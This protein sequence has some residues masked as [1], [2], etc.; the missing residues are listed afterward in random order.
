MEATRRTRTGPR[1]E[2]EPMNG[3]M[4]R[5]DPPAGAARWNDPF[6]RLLRELWNNGSATET[7]LLS[8]AIDVSE[9]DSWIAV[10][11][12]L[13]GL[14]RKDIEVSV[15]DGVLSIRGEKRMEEEA[16]DAKFHR[17]ERRY[18]AFYRALSL[19]ETVDGGNIEARFK[20]GVL[21]V[22]LPKRAETKP[23]RID[24]KE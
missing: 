23:R 6:D 24:V 12:E 9:T 16:K 22:T 3:N 2:E 8:P 1:T 15:K 17:L 21:R 7:S 5:F 10:T 11:A 18:G 13:P 14:E 19:P 4:M 20:D